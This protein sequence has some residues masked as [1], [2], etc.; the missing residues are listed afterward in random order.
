[1]ANWVNVHLLAIGLPADVERFRVAA[2]AR[3]GPIDVRR[4]T[5]FTG[6]MSYGE[7]ADLQADRATRCGR[8]FRAAGYRF[9]GRNDDHVSHFVEVSRRF[10]AL[11]FTLTY[12]DPN[13]DD[14]G[15][16]LLLRGR[17]R[18]WVV[19]PL[20]RE[21]LFWRHFRRWGITSREA[22]TEEENDA[23]YRAEND[24]Y[25]DMMDLAQ[26]H[27]LRPARVWLRRHPARRCR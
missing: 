11:A 5:V 7:S 4:S 22:E 25:L 10:P 20:T 21:R 24:A 13:G 8:R 12:S 3:V 26:R 6:E 2:G 1:M 16:Y 23:L 27:W 17:R 19:P 15:S 9:Q 18:L 14:H